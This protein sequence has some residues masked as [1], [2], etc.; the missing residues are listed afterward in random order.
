MVS[1]SR[2]AFELEARRRGAVGEKGQ[3]HRRLVKPNHRGRIEAG[4]DHH[5]IQAQMM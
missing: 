4:R 3:W 1:L 5:T 2:Y